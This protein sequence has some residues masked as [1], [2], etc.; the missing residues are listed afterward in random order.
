MLITTSKSFQHDVTDTNNCPFQSLYWEG[1]L[2]GSERDEV[3][4]RHPPD[5]SVVVWDRCEQMCWRCLDLI[6]D[7]WDLSQ[8]SL[9]LFTSLQTQVST[10]LVSTASMSAKCLKQGGDPMMQGHSRHCSRNSV[11]RRGTPRRR[12]CSWNSTDPGS[13]GLC[14]PQRA[15]VVPKMRFDKTWV[16]KS[17]LQNE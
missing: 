17:K 13:V 9:P 4:R 11:G 3:Q 5:W 10:T 7:L 1:C 2:S 12:A 8:Q 6:S 14:W 15:P 16:P